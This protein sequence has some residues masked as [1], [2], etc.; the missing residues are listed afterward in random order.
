MAARL[1]PPECPTTRRTEPLM[2]VSSSPSAHALIGGNVRKFGFSS[3]LEITRRRASGRMYPPV[4]V[5]QSWMGARSSSSGAPDDPPN[6]TP[7]ARLFV[8]SPHT[9][10][11]NATRGNRPPAKSTKR[12]A[13]GGGVRISSARMA[14]SVLSKKILIHTARGGL[15]RHDGGFVPAFRQ[16]AGRGRG[17]RGTRLGP[18]GVICLRP[19]ENFPRRHAQLGVTIACARPAAGSPALPDPHPLRR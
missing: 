6:G 10:P 11:Q 17:W 16:I 18:A 9:R 8:T 13:S 15:R 5:R 3:H 2:R 1:H 14:A 12:R 4:P 7:D 19:V